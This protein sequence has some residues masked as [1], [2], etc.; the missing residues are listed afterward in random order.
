MLFVVVHHAWT[1]I[2]FERRYC[3]QSI[4]HYFCF[5][6]FSLIGLKNGSNA[7]H[8]RCKSQALMRFIKLIPFNSCGIQISSFL[9]NP[10]RC[11][12]RSIVDFGMFYIPSISRTVTWCSDSIM[13]LIWLS[14]TSFGRL[15][16]CSS[17]SKK[18]PKRNLSKPISTLSIF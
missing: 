5:F 10:K 13:A 2:V 12:W 9:T 6:Q 17:L 1:M 4:F 7:L 14:S 11:I 8:L 16:R 15:E 18:S 3:K